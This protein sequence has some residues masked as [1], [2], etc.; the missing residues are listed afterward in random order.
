MRRRRVWS[1]TIL[2][3]AGGIAWRCN[4]QI[5]NAWR[6]DDLADAGAATVIFDDGP[7]ADRRIQ[8][9]GLPKVGARV[10][11][12]RRWVGFDARDGYYSVTE[13]SLE[14]RSARAL[15]IGNPGVV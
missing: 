12:S 3:V 8:L 6:A 14:S 1:A 9:T 2:L 10:F 13:M 7:W 11:G 4:Q 15:W 5:R